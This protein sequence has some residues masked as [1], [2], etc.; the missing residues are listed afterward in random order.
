MNAGPQTISSRPQAGSQ[1]VAALRRVCPSRAGRARHGLK[2]EIGKD[3]S[4]D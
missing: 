4:Y 1:D 3:F 2:A